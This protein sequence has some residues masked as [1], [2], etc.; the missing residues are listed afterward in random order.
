MSALIGSIIGGVA[1]RFFGGGNTDDVANYANQANWHW[2]KKAYALANRQFREA[3]RQF[4]H[5][6]RDSRRAIEHRVQDARRAGIH[7][8]YALG[9][10]ANVS[11]TS[12]GGFS[13]LGAHGGT[14]S[15]TGSTMGD[16]I[17]GLAQGA[18]DVYSQR[19]ARKLADEEM[20][21]RREMHE[22]EL[23]Q[24]R[25]SASVDWAAA[26]KVYSD[27]AVATQRVH[28]ARGALANVP[29][30]ELPEVPLTTSGRSPRYSARPV[31]VIPQSSITG[32][33]E[34]VNP[35]GRMHLTTPAT[36]FEELLQA[37]KVLRPP[38]EWS[39]AWA[40]YGYAKAK[41][42]W[43]AFERFGRGYNAKVWRKR[44]GK[45]KLVPLNDRWADT[46][47]RKLMR[48]E[49]H[50][51]KAPRQRFPQNQAR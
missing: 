23:E 46:E 12:S 13:P 43:H 7:P 33:T 19:Q 39:W 2:N 8:L 28:S 32:G 41:R 36:G 44:N 24:R 22:A 3:R 20:M 34:I 47:A 37:E 31:E 45:W 42:L 30:P 4:R 26:Q 27:V 15:E 50:R 51:A 40:K 49:Y 9:M 1:S 18:A 48:G 16:A 11:P 38:I 21:M 25:A 29:L 14:A 6:R 10:S 35:N 5:M 17:K